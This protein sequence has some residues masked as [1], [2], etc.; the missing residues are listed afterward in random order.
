MVEVEAEGKNCMKRGGLRGEVWE[1]IGLGFR[2]S[3]FYSA[4]SLPM[5][6]G[7]MSRLLLPLVQAVD[8]K[9][10]LVDLQG[11]VARRLHLVPSGEAGELLNK[12]GHRRTGRSASAR[13][14]CKFC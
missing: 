14:Q 13:T 5:P 2:L 11:V 7:S 8:R 12:C 4:G 1:L 3:G 9:L 6:P 10:H